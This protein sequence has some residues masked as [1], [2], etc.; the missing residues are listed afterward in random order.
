M[1]NFRYF[2][3]YVQFFTDILMVQKKDVAS[4]LEDFV[5]SGL[6]VK[7]R[8]ENGRI[9]QSP[10]FV[11]FFEGLLHALIFVGYGLEFSLPGMIIEGLA[12]AAVHRPTLGFEEL[13]SPSHETGSGDY[14]IENLTLKFRKSLDTG[15]HGAHAFTI[16]AH[17]M[18]D[19]MLV[20]KE[21]NA[22]DIFA[23][24]S[25]KEGEKSK[26]LRQ[27]SDRWSFNASDAKEVERKIEELQWMNTLIFT[28]AGF[29]KSKQDD[30]RADFYFMHLV[31]SSLFLPSLTAHLSPSSQELLLRGYFAISLALYVARGRPKIDSKPLFEVAMDDNVFDPEKEPSIAPPALSI[32]SSSSK[33]PKEPNLWLPLISR[34]I[35]HPDDHVPK[36]QRAVAHYATFLMSETAPYGTWES[37][38]TAESITG[39]STTRDDVIVDPVTSIIYHLESRPAEKGRCVLVESETGREIVGKDVNVRTGVH[40]YGSASAIVHDGIAYYS[41]IIDNRVYKVNV[42]DGSPA[43]PI[44]PGMLF[45]L[46]QQ[47]STFSDG[48]YAENKAF[49]YACFNI[50]PYNPR[51]LVSILEDHTVNTPSTVVNTL[52]II[53]TQAKTVAP[54]V[55]GADFYALPKFSPDGGKLAWQHWDHPNMPWDNSQISLA[56]VTLADSSLTLSNV[57]TTIAKEGSNG[58]LAWAN[59]NTLCWVCDVSGFGNPWKYDVSTKKA[60][61]IFPSPVKEEFGAAMWLFCFFPFVIVD[62]AGKLGVFKAY[63][64]G[65]A[66]LYRVDIETGDR[67]QIESPYVVVECMRLVSKSKGQF[68][69]LGT[70]VDHSEKVVVGTIRDTVSFTAF[71]S[72]TISKGPNFDPSLVSVPRGIPLKAPPNDELLHVIYYPPHNP[73]YAGTSIEGEKPPCVVNVHGG[74]TGMAQQ[75][76]SWKI[77]YWTTR[78]FAWLDVNYGGSF[79]YG[80]EYINRLWHGWGAVD[81]EDCITASLLLAKPP[82]SLIDPSRIVIRGS[83]SGGLTVL[84]A[85]CNSSDTEVYAAATSLYG[86]TDLV[87]MVKDTHKFESQYMFS[88][89]G[90]SPEDTKPFQKRSP[91]NYVDKIN[92][93]LLILQGDID[94][95]VPK[96]QAEVV[97]NSIKN[98]GGVV[99]YKLYPG[100]G[101]GF[102]MKESQCDAFERELDFYQRALGLREGVKL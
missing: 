16:L 63:R 4:V 29:K 70:K 101:H 65:R 39:N 91:I 7:T 5:F 33:E 36:F 66:V 48:N 30:F 77:Q 40:E 24:L 37:P 58:F 96:E 74:P 76:L 82:H 102:R 44:T 12:L 79:G 26:L 84:N 32:L 93:P 38:I 53:D 49:R 43:E 88:L 6:D 56:E 72:G 92:R 22:D 75:G 89:V 99:E 1:E 45:T 64:D 27:Y 95:V 23:F 87:G 10:L 78:G 97:Y 19:P 50:H 86:V 52:V 25:E 90:G 69:F 18:K 80:K 41:N 51:F 21:A 34:A 2:N 17:V 9:I 31:T 100:E 71:T 3:A 61:P 8:D 94:R 62:N 81:V 85:L 28:V 11:P 15:F 54:L 67:E 68:A 46:S 73:A 98:R 59:R 35:L 42:K 13:V 83:S 47:I 20:V 14:D 60:G 55:S 57:T